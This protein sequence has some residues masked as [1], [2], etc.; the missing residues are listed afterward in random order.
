MAVKKNMGIGV[1]FLSS[2]KTEVLRGEFRRIKLLGLDLD[3]QSYIVYRN[4]SVSPHIQDFI[5]TLRRKF[6]KF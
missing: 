4:H 2:I 3:V 5:K 6:S 1:L